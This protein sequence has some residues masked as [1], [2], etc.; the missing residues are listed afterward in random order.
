MYKKIILIL[1]ICIL[2]IQTFPTEWL[3]SML[4]KTNCIELVSTNNPDEDTDEDTLKNFKIKLIEV[5]ILN[6]HN[7][8]LN[9][10]KKVYLNYVDLVVFNYANEVICPPPNYL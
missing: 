5:D 1:V 7:K 9:Y 4:N 3:S 8:Y 6:S 10:T 2:T